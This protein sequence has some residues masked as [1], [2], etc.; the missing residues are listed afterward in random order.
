MG[1]A[2]AKVQYDDI[3]TLKEVS[4][5]SIYD[6]HQYSELFKQE[7]IYETPKNAEYSHIKPTL[8]IPDFT[9]IYETTDE[10]YISSDTTY[11]LADDIYDGNVPRLTNSQKNDQLIKDLRK[12][13]KSY[14]KISIDEF[15]RNG[16]YS[17]ARLHIWTD[18]FPECTIAINSG[19]IHFNHVE[20]FPEIGHKYMKITDRDHDKTVEIN[21]RINDFVQ[22]IKITRSMALRE[23]HD[24]K[25]HLPF[26]CYEFPDKKI[27]IQNNYIFV[28]N[29]T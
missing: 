8:I 17:N 26:L 20:K 21:K 22:Q 6:S 15:S 18:Y 24:R 9:P 7:A 13:F 28:K 19:L 10:I 11:S 27:F 5:P 14:D 23:F 25:L 2:Q 3:K 29:I 12:Y 1:C 16:Q 4:L